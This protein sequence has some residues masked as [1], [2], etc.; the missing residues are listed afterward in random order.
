MSDVTRRNLLLLV[1]LLGGLATCAAG[2]PAYGIVT[3]LWVII[4]GL[5]VL[6]DIL[7]DILDSL[8]G[9]ESEADYFARIAERRWADEQRRLN[10]KT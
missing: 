4:A 8:R 9:I 7:T 6:A 3:T 2:H 5:C 10:D 1:G